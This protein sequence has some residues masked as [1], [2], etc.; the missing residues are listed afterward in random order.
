[1]LMALCCDQ[2]CTKEKKVQFAVMQFQ[3][4]RITIFND[5]LVY[6]AVF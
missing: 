5:F 4:Q 2:T 1:M 3:A 6:I